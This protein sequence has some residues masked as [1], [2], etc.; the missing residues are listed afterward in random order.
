MSDRKLLLILSSVLVLLV[1]SGLFV[2]DWFF[3]DEIIGEQTAGLIIGI[4]LGW[5]TSFVAFE[6]TRESDRDGTKEK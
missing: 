6:T 3:N 4:A 1:M 2:T 5:V